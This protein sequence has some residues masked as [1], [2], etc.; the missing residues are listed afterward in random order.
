MNERTQVKLLLNARQELPLLAFMS[1]N[2]NLRVPIMGTW[3][4]L[5]LALAHTHTDWLAPIRR[6]QR[7]GWF[8]HLTFESFDSGN[9]CLS[10]PALRVS[11]L[12][13]LCVVCKLLALTD[14]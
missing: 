7:R 11:L 9:R 13:V 3:F 5:F 10:P 12:C 8:V 14:S 6:K 1:A 2:V 4:A